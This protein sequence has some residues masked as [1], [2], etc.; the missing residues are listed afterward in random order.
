MPRGWLLLPLLPPLC[1]AQRSVAAAAAA[2][3]AAA[4]A[5][6]DFVAVIV[7]VGAAACLLLAAACLL[8]PPRRSTFAR[9]AADADA[10]AP[11]PFSTLTWHDVRVDASAP[12]LR[13][14][15]APRPLLR[16]VSGS[17]RRGELVALLG[18]SGSGKST[19]LRLLAGERS[20]PGLRAAADIC[21]D[22]AHAPP[23]LRRRAL[24]Y[25]P[26]HDALPGWLTAAEAVAFGAALRLPPATAPAAAA[27]A[28]AAA[29]AELGLQDALHT[30]VAA[31]SGGE[32]RRC[33]I[34]AELAYAPAVLLC[35]ECTSGLDAFHALALLRSLRSLAAGGRA[36][37]VA[38]HTPGAESFALFDRATLLVGGRA[39]WAGPAPRADGGEALRALFDRRASPRPEERSL[40]EHLLCCALDAAGWDDADVAAAAAAACAPAL[41][42][43]PAD[44]PPAAAPAEAPPTDA[45]AAAAPP[46]AAPRAP[47]GA[48]LARQLRW[49]FWREALRVRRSPALL[50][51]HT[52]LALGLGVWLGVIYY[53]LDLSIYGFQSRLGVYFFVL[54]SFGFSALSAAGA[55]AA[56]AALLAQEAHR[57]AHP[58]AFAAARLGADLLL[59]R[60][61]PA[62][63]HVCVLYFMVGLQPAAARFFA[64]LAAVVLHALAAAALTALVSAAAPAPGVALLLAS[65]L[66]L[67][68][69]VFGGLLTSTARLPSW[70]AWLRFTSLHYYAFEAAVATEFSGLTFELGIAGIAG[71]AFTGDSLLDSALALQQ[72]RVGADLACLAAWLLCFAAATCAVVAAKHAPRGA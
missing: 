22:G 19:L 16:G 29:C 24:G 53:Q 59:L 70:L 21:L 71:I 32:L 28:A 35:D 3:E 67:Q 39:V 46:A 37:L 56:D 26:Q 40:A 61:P 20:A 45:P 44:A 25:V 23:A 47:P 48:P 60:L 42:D 66:S 65:F 7:A 2:A 15:A 69:A 8:P 62:A 34:A 49:L 1:G 41:A 4:Y 30:R 18:P 52:L 68:M 13:R 17:L 11:P 33:A 72:A 14:G 50:A 57:A 6:A 10:L 5:S 63:I 64:C 58:A 12:L 31:L 27:A 51:A 38:I 55:F 9:A 54:A 43:S 36:V